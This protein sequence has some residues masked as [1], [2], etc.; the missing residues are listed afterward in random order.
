[1]APAARAL[2]VELGLQADA[3]AVSG[4]E[5]YELLF[6]CPPP[7]VEEIRNTLAQEWRTPVHVIGEITH[8][9]GIIFLEADGRA[10]PVDGGFDHFTV[11]R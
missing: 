1:M 10:R 5:D 8:E 9:S 6:T 4:G 3:L 11:G 7:A 2:A